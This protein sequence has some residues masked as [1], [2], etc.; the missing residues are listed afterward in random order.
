MNNSQ[1]GPRTRHSHTAGTYQC[2]QKPKQ[3][4]NTRTHMHAHKL[5]CIFGHL[6]GIVAFGQLNAPNS[7]EFY[8]QYI[9]PWSTTTMSQ[10]IFKATVTA[11]T[12][13][14]KR[15]LQ[16]YRHTGFWCVFVHLFVSHVVEFLLVSMYST[17]KMR[18][19]PLII[20]AHFFLVIFYFSL[21]S[22]KVLIVFLKTFF[23]CFVSL[24]C[25]R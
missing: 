14:I 1:N 22:K 15:V 19:T 6:N 23:L 12:A 25:M 17:L 20:Q 3:H 24:F 2:C 18:H 9:S 13:T 16:A 8:L 21:S 7:Y 10:D 5:L 4:T 11:T